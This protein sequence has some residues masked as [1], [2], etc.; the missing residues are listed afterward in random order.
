MN[1]NNKI[2][3]T[4]EISKEREYYHETQKKCTSPQ[5]NSYKK[6]TTF[7]RHLFIALPH[8]PAKKKD[9]RHY[10]KIQ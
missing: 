10:R 5:I 9:V 7:S 3:C 4:L 6:R 1:I 2:M 8:L